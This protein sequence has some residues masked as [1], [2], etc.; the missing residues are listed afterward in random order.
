MP[1]TARGP[2]ASSWGGTSRCL[3]LGTRGLK[4]RHRHLLRDL[5]HILPHG[6][7]GPKVGAKQGLSAIAKLCE[8]TDCTSAV[9]LDARDTQRLYLWAVGCPN[10]P[11][12][13]FRVLNVHT[14]AELNL[15][16]RRVLQ[17]RNLLS[18]DSG[19]EACAE[20]RLLKALLARM[21]S[22]PDL[23]A[24]CRCAL[25]VKH[26]LIF[27]FVDGRIW[28]RV[29]RNTKDAHGELGVEEIGPRLVLQPVR[30]I[31]CCFGGAVLSSSGNAAVEAEAAD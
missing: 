9:L 11:S 26:T 22:V 25:R 17:V 16:A 6:Q 15:S 5:L 2:R 3:L 8:D 31:A 21:F 12:A 18:F 20:R 30:L 4:A 24:G 29:F 28:V 23:E 10:G 19:F 14:V 13:M 7:S 1:Q 27:S